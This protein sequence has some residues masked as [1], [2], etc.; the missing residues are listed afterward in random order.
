MSLSADAENLGLSDPAT[1]K[2]RF[3]L[4]VPLK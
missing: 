1:Y 4:S 2:S 3:Q